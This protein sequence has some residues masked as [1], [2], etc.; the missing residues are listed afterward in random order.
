MISDALNDAAPVYLAVVAICRDRA[1]GC[2]L[3]GGDTK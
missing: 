3:P 1:P 2:G